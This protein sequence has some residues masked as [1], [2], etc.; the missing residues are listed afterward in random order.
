M[1]TSIS[2]RTCRGIDHVNQ[3]KTAVDQVKGALEDLVI[4]R[5]RT[6]VTCVEIVKGG[7]TDTLFGVWWYRAQNIGEWFSGLGF[8]IRL[9]FWREPEPTRGIIA[10]LASRQSK[11]IESLWPSDAYISRWTILPV[12]L[13]GLA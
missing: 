5:S 4:E 2:K 12:G 10:K 6:M 1:W 8:E 11:V 7:V 3:V 9:G 13:S